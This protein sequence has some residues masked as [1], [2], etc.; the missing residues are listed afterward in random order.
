FLGGTALTAEE[1]AGD[2]AGGVG[3]LFDVDRQR[4]EVDAGADVLGGVG[5]G[6]DGR[7]PDRGHDGALTLR[8]EFAGL[9][10]E[11][12]VGTRHRSGYANGISHEWLLSAAAYRRALE[13]LAGSQLATPRTSRNQQPATNRCRSVLGR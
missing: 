8:G 3:A 10:R 9:E 1:R 4:E 12:L 5:R 7:A 11:G 2:L 6:E 13:R